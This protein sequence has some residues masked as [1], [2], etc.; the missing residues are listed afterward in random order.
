[1]KD[2]ELRDLFHAYRPELGDEEAFMDKLSAQM[3]AADEKQTPRVRPLYRKFLPWMAGIAAAI[4]VA[5]LFIKPTD[6]NEAREATDYPANTDYQAFLAMT[7]SF[8]SFEET[9]ANIEQSGKQLEQ[10]IGELKE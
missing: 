5:L 4:V 6:G 7:T 2:Q 10:A 9:V 8:P 3:D 1:M